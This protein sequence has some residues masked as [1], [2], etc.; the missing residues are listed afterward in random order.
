[1]E[2]RNC[3]VIIVTADLIALNA[4]LFDLVHAISLL[5]RAIP[6]LRRIYHVFPFRQE[7]RI[8]FIKSL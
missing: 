6:F 1:M 5:P 8:S 7:R 2:N 4:P 3:F